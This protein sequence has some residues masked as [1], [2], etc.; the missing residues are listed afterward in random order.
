MEKPNRNAFLSALAQLLGLSG[1]AQGQSVPIVQATAG[2]VH[3][4]AL[5]A[6]GDVWCWGANRDG[7]LGDG[8]FTDRLT[9]TKVPGLQN[10]LQIAAGSWHTCA[11]RANNRVSCW[12]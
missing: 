9:P 10:V 5:D 4:C 11:I 12:G 1:A 7:Q 8:T 2:N 6:D 3:T